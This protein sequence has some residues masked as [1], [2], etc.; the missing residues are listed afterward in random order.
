MSPIEGRLIDRIAMSLDLGYNVAKANGVRQTTF[1]Y[2]VS[3]RA[4]ERLITANFDASRSSNNDSPTSIRSNSGFSYRRFVSDRQWDPIGFGAVERNDELGLDRR[5]TVGGGMSRWIS[6][7]NSRRVSF[8]G[9]VVATR[10]NETGATESDQSM[11]AVTA[12]QL[13][14]FRYDDPELDVAM[15]FSVYERL[16]DTRR[17]RGNLD[18]D[19]R[20]E[21]INDFFW[22]FSIYYSFNSEPTGVEASSKDY[23]I[24]TS[25][26]W[27]F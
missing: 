21:L 3:Y 22:G 8:T 5:L 13:D 4:E 2:D 12:I 1:G 24:V 19:V 9:G 23:G 26:G 27:S 16:S 11:E 7:T 10:E 25:I 14:W 17:T 20:W 6:D 18:L 15:R